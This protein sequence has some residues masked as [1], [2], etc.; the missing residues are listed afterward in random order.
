MFGCDDGNTFEYTPLSPT[1]GETGVASLL[2]AHT[3][4]V[5][6]SRGN[7]EVVVSITIEVGCR[8]S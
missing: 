2:L 5:E 3:E 1:D 4:K 6:Y 8:V 7:D